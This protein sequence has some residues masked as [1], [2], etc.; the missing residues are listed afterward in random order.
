MPVASDLGPARRLK[1]RV[2]KEDKQVSL[3]GEVAREGQRD[4]AHP[5]WEL[6]VLAAGQQKNAPW[7]SRTMDR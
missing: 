5:G 4:G 3:F 6:A 2:E 1:S 7:G